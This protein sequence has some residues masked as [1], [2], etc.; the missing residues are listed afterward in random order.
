MK[1]KSIRETN[2]LKLVNE[3]IFVKALTDV[4]YPQKHFKN[5]K[6][7]YYFWNEF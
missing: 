1:N 5:G 7:K 4:F 6:V 2:H 3:N